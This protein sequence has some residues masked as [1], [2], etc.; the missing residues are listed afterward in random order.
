MASQ[1]IITRRLCMA[2]D[3]EQYSRL[4]S[5]QQEA[6]QTDLVRVL[7]GAAALTGLD[8]SAWARQA[9]GD[10]EF[11]VLPVDTSESVVLGDFVRHLGVALGECNANRPRRTPMR[12]RLAL[13]IGVALSAALGHSGP[14]PVAVA[15]YLNAPQL[16]DVLKATRTTNLVVIVSDRVYQ[17]VIRLRGNELDPQA[18]IKVHVQDGDFAGYGWIHAPEHSPAEL[19]GLPV[20]VRGNHTPR[21]SARQPEES[22]MTTPEQVAALA[23][24]AIVGA[25]ATDA[26]SYVRTRCAALLGRHAPSEG[27]EVLTLLDA[28]EQALDSS[29]PTQRD[30]LVR[31]FTD[32]ITTILAAVAHRSQESAADVRA[33]SEEAR[34]AP[35]GRPSHSN[36]TYRNIKAQGD[37]IWSGRD[38]NFSGERE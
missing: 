35:A 23:G 2:A 31:T 36:L 27:Q 19:L 38:T 32:R 3:V 37:F 28:F 33:L 20:D 4:D 13:D 25:M 7:D 34:T 26:W 11:A 5:P 15:R 10:Q 8:R 16:K 30:V 1:D 14:A 6:I 12:L 9:Q 17:D 29:G 22:G 21:A 24:T 18:Y